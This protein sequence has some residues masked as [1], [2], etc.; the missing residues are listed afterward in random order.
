MVG[1]EHA[2]QPDRTGGADHGTLAKYVLQQ[3]VG[4]P[5]APRRGNGLGQRRH[6]GDQEQVG[7]ELHDGSRADRT[8]MG[9]PDAEVG[10]QRVTG[11]DGR[12]QSSD[13]ESTVTDGHVLRCSHDGCVEDPVGGSDCGQV[14]HGVG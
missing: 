6:S 4:D 13:E 7:D 1:I 14:A 8:A 5:V 2:A 11:T 3:L 10:P 12:K 9:I